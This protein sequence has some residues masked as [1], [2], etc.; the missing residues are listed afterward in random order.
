MD[1][2]LICSSIRKRPD[3]ASLFPALLQ[4]SNPTGR[5]KEAKLDTHDLAV[6]LH[7]SGQ[8]AR[9]HFCAICLSPQEVDSL[10]TR[11]RI[12]RLYNLNGGQYVAIVLLMEQHQ[13]SSDT[14]M[15]MKLQIELMSGLEMP[16]IPLSSTR[17]LPATIMAF[18]RQL[19]TS[20]AP[21][22]QAVTAR[23]LLS[24]CSEIHHLGEHTTN[25]LSDI[26]T[27]FRDLVH[28]ATT[29]EGQQNLRDYL[30]NDAERVIKFWQDEYLVE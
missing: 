22:K 9:L 17:E 12:E 27:D 16:I 6:P 18:H 15:M 7:L 1:Y 11:K 24:H 29:L 19:M 23:C 30:G 8:T 20:A 4:S 28:K 21:I 3:W 2:P 14:A 10:E 25:L 5:W 26:T 13:G